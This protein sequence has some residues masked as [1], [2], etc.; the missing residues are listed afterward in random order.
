MN[1]L[2]IERDLIIY[3][4]TELCDSRLNYMIL[5][6]ALDADY[7]TNFYSNATDACHEGNHSTLTC[8]MQVDKSSLISG[9]QE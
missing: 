1:R 5:N 6:Y 7:L 8:I 9:F 4:V 2:A 3:Q